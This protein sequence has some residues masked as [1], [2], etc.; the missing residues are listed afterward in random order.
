M[1]AIAV[2]PIS[3]GPV[4]TAKLWRSSDVE[5]R[6]VRARGDEHAREL[7]RGRVVQRRAPHDVVVEQRL[8]VAHAEHG[9]HAAAHGRARRR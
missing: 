6:A 1:R 8:E 7:A 2:L 9:R 5:R 4:R 3:G